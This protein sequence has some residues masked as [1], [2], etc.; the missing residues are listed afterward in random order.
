MHA[1]LLHLAS[2]L[3]PP[4]RRILTE[5]RL[6]TLTQFAMFGTVGALGF[7]I[8]T[9]TVY[10]L[11]GVIGL[12]WAGLISYFA[13]ASFNWVCNRL[14]TFRGA[15]SGP[16]HRQWARFIAANSVGLVLNRGTYALLVTFFALC[17]RQPVFA[18]AAGTFAGMFI[19]FAL[20]RR[21]VFR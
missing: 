2:Q 18:T 17:A 9:G 20:S 13:A 5:Q 14:W 8:D 19:N 10:A 3:P 12:Y 1:L 15:G 7:V 11:R 4:A 21:L 6:N 16:A